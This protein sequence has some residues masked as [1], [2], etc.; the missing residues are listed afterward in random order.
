M[1]FWKITK[2]LLDTDSRSTAVGSGCYTREKEEDME[3]RFKL[4]D[5]DDI[6]YYEGIASEPEFDPLDW[7]MNY[8]GCTRV[9]FLEDGLWKTL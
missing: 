7:G 6:L 1:V 9:D 5:D 2:D 4:Y 8:A 3:Y